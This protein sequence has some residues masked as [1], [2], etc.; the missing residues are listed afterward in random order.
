MGFFYAYM[1]GWSRG[2][3]HWIANPVTGVRFPLPALKQIKYENRK[4]QRR[5]NIKGSRE[6]M[7]PNVVQLDNVFN[8]GKIIKKLLKTKRK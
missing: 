2:I 4:R 1:L 5:K 7:R 6:I 3:R 8:W